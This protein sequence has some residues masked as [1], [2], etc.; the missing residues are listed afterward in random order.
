MKNLPVYE[1]LDTSFVNLAALV[2]FLRERQF[3]GNLALQLDGYQAEIVFDGRGGISASEHDRIAGRIAEGDEAYARLLIR[4]RISGGTINVYQTVSETFESTVDLSLSEPQSFE[5]KQIVQNE[6]SN[7][8]PFPAASFSASKDEPD[9]DLIEEAERQN[10]SPVETKPSPLPMEFSNRVEERAR[11]QTSATTPAEWQT[12]LQ[13]TGELLG[14]IDKTL[15]GAGLNFQA[16]FAKARVEIADDY[17][18][19][20]SSPADSFFYENGVVEMRGAPVN[21]K[22][23]VAGINEALRRMLEKLGANPKYAEVHRQT[24][25]RILA[26]IYSRRDLYDKFSITPQIEKI[27]GVL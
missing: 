7:L 20:R 26:L 1:N 27:L 25:Q 10:S 21:A 2:R 8:L 15:A 19:F 3:A 16:A 4:A 17:P 14:A 13:I 24:V 23:F 11:R 9:F 18:F 22:I 12:L 5:E 6:F